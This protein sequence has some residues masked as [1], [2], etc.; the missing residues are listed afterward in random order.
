[1]ARPQKES[2]DYF[3]MDVEKDNKLKFLK[4]KFGVMGFGTYIEFLQYIYKQGYYT[5]WD[6]DNM[7][8]FLT[9]TGLKEE[10]TKLMLEFML[11]K[12]L[13]NKKLFIKYNILTSTW[14]QKRYAES[15]KKRRDV[16]VVSQ[17]RIIGW[18][19]HIKLMDTLIEL[20]EEETP[21]K[22]T[23]STQRKVKESKGKKTII[24]NI[25]SGS[26]D[27]IKNLFKEYYDLQ[28]LEENKLKFYTILELILL[29]REVERSK[30]WIEEKIKTIE[31]KCIVCWIV[32]TIGSI[33][34][35][36][37]YKASVNMRIRCVD[38]G[39]TTTRFMWRFWKFLSSL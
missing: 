21:K 27:E 36:K 9:E 5:V 15:T 14:I 8:L 16:S 6:D 23:E 29:W 33:D 35:D 26:R 25:I 24:T 20:K 11:E 3:S 32:N 30:E 7:L 37:A 13:F 31:D 28:Y 19:K 12:E 39:S 38:T 1:M 22:V 34:W 2:L 18:Y 4:W 10:E 17:Y